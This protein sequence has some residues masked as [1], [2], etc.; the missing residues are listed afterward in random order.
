MHGLRQAPG[1]VLAHGWSSLPETEAG[2]ACGG[3]MEAKTFGGWVFLGV[4]AG[5]GLWT[6]YR[7]GQQSVRRHLVGKGKG[8]KASEFSAKEVRMGVEH[9]MEHTDDPTLAE[10]I[11][12]DHLAETPDYYTRL[13]AVEP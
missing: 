5:L 4:L 13:E 11:A 9:E 3:V 7:A 2:M 12:I 8:R 10:Q 6:V 1:L